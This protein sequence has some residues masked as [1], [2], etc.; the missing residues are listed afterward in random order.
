MKRFLYLAAATMAICLSA[1]ATYAQGDSLRLRFHVPFAFTAQK[2]SFPAG[3]YEITQPARMVLELR[4]LKDQ[5]ASF[6]HAL[7]ASSKEADGRVKVVF[8]RY[9][10]EY[11]LSLVSTGSRE[12]TY[13]FQM[14]KEER[15][16]ADASPRPQLKVASVLVN[17]TGQTANADQK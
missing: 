4:N 12:S 15:R 5:A 13:C 2:A 10:S 17:G 16:I 6:E 14:S 1:T 7:P 3:E 8:H 9:G 11:F